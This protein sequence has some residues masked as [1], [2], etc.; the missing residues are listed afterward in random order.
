MVIRW[1]WVSV[2]VVG[3]VKTERERENVHWFFR[4]RK[5]LNTEGDGRSLMPRDMVWFLR[6]FEPIC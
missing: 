6:D 2:L 1:R 5:D 4:E 3:V